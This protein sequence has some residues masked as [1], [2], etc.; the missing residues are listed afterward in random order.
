MPVH[1]E[2]IEEDHQHR[3]DDAEEVRANPPCPRRKATTESRTRKMF[4]I[5]L[6]CIVMGFVFSLFILFISFAALVLVHFL[7][8]STAGRRRRR[9]R[10]FQQDSRE[11]STDSSIHSSYSME[12]LQ[13]LLPHLCYTESSNTSVDCAI[14]LESVEDGDFCRELPDCKHLFHANCIDNWLTK[15]PN[16]PICRTRVQLDSGASGSIHRDDEWKVWSPVALDDGNVS[17]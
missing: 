11:L 9:R 12:D 16:C 14:C 1:L 17:I 4:F 2:E 15:V 7:L 6:K 3:H 10:R 8:T 13:Q 5:L